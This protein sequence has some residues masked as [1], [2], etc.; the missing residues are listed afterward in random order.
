MTADAALPTAAPVMKAWKTYKSTLEFASTKD[1][2]RH[3]E[4]TEGALWAA[5]YEG[6]YRA[7]L[8]NAE[9]ASQEPSMQDEREQIARIID[10]S[11]WVVFDGYLADMKRKYAVQNIGYDLGEFRDK[12]SI[13]K[14]DQI[15]ALRQP[16]APQWRPIAE[17]PRDGTPILAA[18]GEMFADNEIFPEY[19]PVQGVFIVVWQ[20]RDGSGG[21]D[22]WRGENVGSH[23]EWFW[24][25]PTHFMLFP[26]PPS[27][28]ELFVSPIRD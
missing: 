3:V 2:A 21:A 28:G 17:A 18:N 25:R 6:F 10:P 22:G 5:F 19:R 20:Y 1:H 23:D 15:L 7:A 11:A 9:D 8:R 13:A 14:A 24:H 4:R 26:T 16:P 27:S 12:K